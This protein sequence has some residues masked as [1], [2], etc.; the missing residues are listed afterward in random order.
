MLFRSIPLSLADAVAKAKVWLEQTCP[1][2]TNFKLQ[3]VSLGRVSHPWIENR[4]SYGLNF[5]ATAVQN[6]KGAYSAVS[7]TF[8]IWLLLD[9][10][11]VAPKILDK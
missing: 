2:F 11:I 7:R 3:R 6:N 4:W 1:D 10:T 9:G 5:T 8:P